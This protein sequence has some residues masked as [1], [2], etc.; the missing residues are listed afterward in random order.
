MKIKI[1]QISDK[2]DRVPPIVAYFASGYDPFAKNPESRVIETPKVTVYR[3]KDESKKRLQ[4]V[5]SPPD[6]NVEFVGSNYTG[7]QTAR[8]T[9]V[10]KLGVLNKETRTLKILPIAHNKIVRLEPRV[11]KE[12]VDLE[13]SEGSDT[14]SSGNEDISELTEEERLKRKATKKLT[15]RFCTEQVIN[16][17]K[18]K[19]GLNLGYDPLTKELLKGKLNKV[20]VKASALKSNS[21]VARN[22]PPYDTS[23]TTPSEAYPIQKIIEKG[24]WLFLQDIY[25]LLQQ[26]TEAVTDNY[27]LFVSNRLYKLRAIKDETEKAD[28]LW[29][30]I[31]PN[32][33][34]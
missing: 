26:E 14:E 23:A 30:L 17:N 31:T 16:R 4:V 3:H 8:Q 15:K 21:I 12:T 11:I 33:Y 13:A 29:C 7:E 28:G 10:Y 25:L 1:K 22:I 19:R 5:V 18:K 9:C 20:N 27:P 6:S 24:E 34:G 2:S 32:T